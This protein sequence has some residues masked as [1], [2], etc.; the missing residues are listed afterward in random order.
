VSAAPV[1]PEILR[2]FLRDRFLFAFFIVVGFV[3]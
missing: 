1:M 2:K 3:G